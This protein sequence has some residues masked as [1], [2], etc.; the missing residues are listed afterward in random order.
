MDRGSLVSEYAISENTE[1]QFFDRTLAELASR[2][3]GLKKTKMPNA[4][5]ALHSMRMR[6][7]SYV[8]LIKMLIL[9]LVS[10]RFINFQYTGTAESLCRFFV[11]R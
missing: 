3:S 1:L 4:S 7:I 8:M 5:N 10:R 11:A 2:L 6:A 9:S